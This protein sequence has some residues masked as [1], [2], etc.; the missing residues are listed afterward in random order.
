MIFARQFVWVYESMAALLDLISYKDHEWKICADLKVVAM[1]TGLQQGYTKYC[2]FLCKWDSRARNYHYVKKYWPKRVNFIMGQANVKF[3]PLVKLDNIILPPLHIKLGLFKNFVKA[4]QKNGPSFDY[5][6]SVFPNLSEAK[7]KEGVFVGPQIKKLLNDSKFSS[8]LTANEAKA[9]SSFRSVVNGFLGNSRSSDY[10]KIVEDLLVNYKKIGIH[11]KKLISNFWLIFLNIFNSI[12]G[13][14]VNMSLKIHFLHSHL[15]F[16]PENLGDESD[17]HG[18]RFHQQ[19]KTMER[20]YQGFWNEAMM[21][22]YCWF[23][24]RETEDIHK[25]RKTSDVTHFWAHHSLWFSTFHLITLII[26]MKNRKK[27][28]FVRFTKTLIT[29]MLFLRFQCK[30]TQNVRNW[31]Y[32]N[33]H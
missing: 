8:T 3:D 13:T 16:F 10:K 4:L 2:C 32:F 21:G 26:S 5:L 6:R 12:L 24:I 14:G 30:A 20:R 23:L 28:L 19:M 17:E 22:D 11:S 33:I 7:I 15:D 18:E 27:T 31:S 25:R 29:S 1:V 9:W